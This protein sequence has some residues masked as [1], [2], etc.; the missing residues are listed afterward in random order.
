MRIDKFTQKMQE[1]VQSSQDL[2]SELGQQEITNEHFLLALLDQ[3]EGITRPLLEKMGVATEPLK[4]QLRSALAKLPRVS[5]SNV[6]LRIGNDLRRVVDSAEKEMAKLKDE[7]VSAEH[8]LLALTNAN[9]PATKLLQERGV[10]RDK[11][12]QALQQ[13]RGSQRVTDQ[14]PEG[15][16]QTLEKYGQDL[17]ERARRGKIDP[18]IGRDNEI[19]RIM[20]VLSRRTKNNP[21]LIGEPGVGKTAIVEGLARRIISGDVPESLKNKRLIAMD[22]G[23]MVAGAKFR[24]EFEDR[25]KAFLKEVTDSEGEIILFI[26]ELHTIV[27]AGAAEGSVD[28]SNLLKPQLARGELRTI[29][30]TTL[31]EYRK[32]IEKDAALE[33]RFQPVMVNEPTV[34]DTIAILR[35]L[36]ERYEVHHG[37]RIRDAAL[38]AAAVLSHR[39]ISDRFLP[40]KAVDLM[41]EAA[42]RLK[43][44]LDSMPTEIDV[45]EREV[46]QL[47]MER[48]ALKKEKDP[49][50]KERLTKLEKELAGLKEKSGGLKAEWQK[51]KGLIDEQRK[52]KEELDALRTELERAQRRGELARASEIQYGRMPEVERQLNELLAK[53]GQTKN[54]L[55]R[56]EVTEEDIAE[57]VS[58]WTH[59]PV[60]RLQE[61]EREKLIKMEERL[62]QRV[63]GQQEA[64][65]AVSNAVRRARA[66]L[67]D[68]NR[69]IGS[70]IFLG[71]TGVGKTELARA[72][73]E[74]LFDDE[75]ATIRI[76]MSEY[77]EKHTVARLIGAP[78]GYVGYEEGGQLS[79][80]VRRKPYSVILFD[81][82]EK[83]HQD[84]FNVLLQV[85][86]DGRITDGQGRTV[87]F[88]NTV[89]IMTSNIGSQFI[90]EEAS[91]EGRSRLVMDALRKHFRPEFINRVDEII[92]FD[93]LNDEELKKIVEIQLHRLTKRLEDRKITLE[94]S[95]TAKERIA[96]EG[97]DP[98]YGA[99]PLKRAIQKEILDPLSLQILEGKFHENQTIR[100]DER[101]GKLVFD[102]S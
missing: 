73:A 45:I 53:E 90:T 16:Y 93:R 60:S 15:K 98:V 26:D 3:A 59:I 49:A 8:Y 76:D 31:N 77:M 33:R 72:L 1:A 24:G 27:G 11:L 54:Q 32:Y 25:L 51:E 43:I 71:P 14:T 30:A 86:D 7:F 34:E 74:F 47:E 4:E 84:V 89:I 63:I 101:D 22:I 80:A 62:M 12:M 95:D 64:I 56:E 100:V 38:V 55:L 28:A 81:E 92:I 44:E 82:I 70:F 58:S 67:Q 40:D 23:A 102:A 94:L 48:Q 46:M 20:Q 99:R 79:E 17:T 87:D 68:E 61:G 19:R 66:G 65:V 96:R 88:K 52:L 83:A 91:S 78:P 6:D 29:G 21:V 42:S 36:K 39:Y 50:S 35:G 75:N 41:D 37:V 69:P 2:A 97:Y 10:T 85:L 5:G 9:V 18:V 57:V 13:V